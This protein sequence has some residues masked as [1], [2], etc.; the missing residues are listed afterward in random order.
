M[1]AKSPADRYQTPVEVAQALQPFCKGDS[2]PVDL[3]TL[4]RPPAAGVSVSHKTRLPPASPAERH[5]PVVIT[6]EK[7]EPR[8]TVQQPTP[9]RTP[10]SLKGKVVLAVTALG[11]L[12]AIALAVIF[13]V[14]TKD[15][16]IEISGLPPSAEVFVD[17]SKATVK[18]VDGTK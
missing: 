4:S 15:G 12:F 2:K 14:R 18:M 16:V 13:T 3:L 17:Q 5:P 11:L 8:P 10:M 9:K 7:D 6:I 1:L